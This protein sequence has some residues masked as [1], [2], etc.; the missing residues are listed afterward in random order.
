MSFRNIRDEGIQKVAS[1]T[2]R[3]ALR[4]DD[5]TIVEQLDTHTLYIYNASSDD[6]EMVGGGGGG[7]VGNFFGTIQTDSGTYPTAEVP[8]DTLT[9]TS[10]DNT[11]YYFSGNALTDRVTLNISGLVSSGGN[12]GQILAKASDSNFDVEWRDGVQVTTVYNQ[13]GTEISKGSV[14]YINGAHGNLPTIGLSKANS[15]LTSSK[16][17][18][19]VIENIP[20]MS[21]GTIVHSGQI[22]NL[23]TFG[24][25]EGVQLWLSPTV[26]GG[27]TT[28][29]PS[30]PNHVVALGICTKA[31][32]TQGTIEVSIENGF[33][34]EE[35]HNVFVN[36]PISGQ[37]LAY[38]SGTSLWKNASAS[39][40]INFKREK[41][42]L[43]PTNVADGYVNL[44]FLAAANS[45]Q[46]YVDRL[47]IFEQMD[48]TTSSI[49]GIYTRATFI[50]D[51]ASG[52]ST[53]IQPGDIVHFF[54][55]QQGS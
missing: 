52:G 37:V 13:T 42:I 33:K 36:T 45:I 3:L 15:E 41:F 29:K 51:L 24:V 32:A 12:Y 27:Y 5:G 23:N 11:K 19:F 10:A 16:T 48:F 44:S 46:A 2:D 34:L 55:T 53:P 31:H 17:Y 43:T 1:A 26:S 50:G 22:R 20:S 14:V 54:Y 47:P 6:W 38:D 9:L 49:A 8:N 40:S 18:G 28:V 39:S 21:S 4:P 25:P 30:A 35:L 7:G